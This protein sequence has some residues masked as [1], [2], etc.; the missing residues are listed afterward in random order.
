MKLY[1]S[2]VQKICFPSFNLECLGNCRVSVVLKLEHGQKNRYSR[3]T[4][5]EA[6]PV[7]DGIDNASW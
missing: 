3:V 2:S 1:G 7:Q 5:P 6:S 4:S